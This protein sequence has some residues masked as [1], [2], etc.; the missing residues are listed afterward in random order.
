MV[1]FPASAIEINELVHAQT[2]PSTDRRMLVIAP[3]TEPDL[4]P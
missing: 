1:A 4:G 2:L 3:P